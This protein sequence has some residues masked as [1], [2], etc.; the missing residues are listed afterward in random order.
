MIKFLSDPR[1]SL[2][3]AGVLIAIG[4]LA[5]AVTLFFSHPM[6]FMG[7][8]F[9]GGS[10]VGLGVLLYLWTIVSTGPQEID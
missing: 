8:I 9:L 1:R 6:A 2:Q 10:L 3:I 4:L 7:F 5:E